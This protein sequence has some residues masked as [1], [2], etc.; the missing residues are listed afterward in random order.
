ML[1]FRPCLVDHVFLLSRSVFSISIAVS[2]AHRI[3]ETDNHQHTSELVCEIVGQISST[4]FKL[5]GR[6]TYNSNYKE[7]DTSFSKVEP[8][9]GDILMLKAVNINYVAKRRCFAFSIKI[10]AVCYLILL[11]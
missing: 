7:S 2:L 1:G 6:P 10:S 4:Q 3:N 8:Q 11:L 5:K 9:T